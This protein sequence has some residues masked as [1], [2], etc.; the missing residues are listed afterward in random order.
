MQESIDKRMENFVTKFK[1]SSK[2]DDSSNKT[3]SYSKTDKEAK[4]QSTYDHDKIK[5]EATS[6]EGSISEVSHLMEGKVSMNKDT[7]LDEEPPHGIKQVTFPSEKEVNV[8]ERQKDLRLTTPESAAPF[9]TITCLHLTQRASM[10]SPFKT[11]RQ[12]TL[13]RLTEIGLDSKPYL[14]NTPENGHN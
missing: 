14:E 8:E 5:Y 4:K 3:S 11:R 13:R 12:S 10:A 9:D 1:G 7:P 6:K 2:D